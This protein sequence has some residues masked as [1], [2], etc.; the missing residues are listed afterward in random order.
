MGSSDGTHYQAPE[1]TYK[2]VDWANPILNRS[3]A[4]H[5]SAGSAFST[6][7]GPALNEAPRM[8]AVS[9]RALNA[10]QPMSG[11]LDLCLTAQG[12]D[13]NPREYCSA[14][15]AFTQRSYAGIYK[16]CGSLSPR[17]TRP[18]TGVKSNNPLIV[19]VNIHK[20]LQKILSQRTE[21]VTVTFVSASKTLLWYINIGQGIQEPVGRVTF[22]QTPVC[23]DVNQFTCLQDRL[24]VLV[25]FAKGDM[26][27]MDPIAMKYTRLNKDGT[28]LS[29]ALRQIRWVP[30]SEN[31]FLS[32]H[33]DG[34]IM[35]LDR[36]R[37]DS[38]GMDQIPMQQSH[39]DSRATMLVSQDAPSKLGGGTLMSRQKE[40]P[41][42]R[43]NPVSYWRVS[44]KAIT[45]IAF[46]PD[47]VRVAVTSEDG[48]WRLIDAD[49]QILLHSFASYF[50]GFTCVCWSPD[51]RLALTGGQDDLLTLWL[52]NEGYI[53]ARAQGHNSFVTGITFDPWY[54]R[55]S[56]DLYRFVSVGEDRNLCFWD[57]SISNLSHPRLH[58]RSWS[59]SSHRRSIGSFRPMNPDVYVPASTRAQVSMLQSM[60]CAKV[61]GGMLSALRISPN[62]LLLLHCDG[63]LDL[64]A[65]PT[66]PRYVQLDGEVD[67]GRTENNLK[68]PPK[69]LSHAFALSIPGMRKG[70]SNNLAYTVV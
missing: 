70:T 49:A 46:S 25:G 34:S 66:S 67:L 62:M 68:G 5:G 69:H 8:S 33:A 19:R 42:E 59:H 60:M 45:D 21:D 1:G 39:W 37:D 27:W 28:M 20:D 54:A 53:L 18:K 38:L 48:L 7:R 3:A 23:H 17:P 11:G 26:I 30:Q 40:T 2:C 44:T 24:D 57:F 4:Q 51:G 63:Q 10:P 13:A 12:L 56:E 55:H 50:G 29:A 41:R 31:L 61:P 14:G 32:A 43:L 15:E 6:P 35:V 64:I 22:S 52:P 9:F 58:G 16:G 65:R 47:H 36:D